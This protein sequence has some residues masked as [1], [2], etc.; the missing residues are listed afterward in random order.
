MKT[1]IRANI[2]A[3]SD[4]NSYVSFWNNM[5]TSSVLST[6]GRHS[7]CSNSWLAYTSRTSQQDIP[8]STEK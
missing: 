4:T 6:D 3:M 5:R 2:R 1:I 7:L 8:F